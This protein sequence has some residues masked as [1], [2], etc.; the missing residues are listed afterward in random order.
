M[1]LKNLITADR[2]EAMLQTKR[3]GRP[4]FAFWRI[5]STNTFARDQAMQGAPEGTLVIA[6][7]QTRGRGRMNRSW[8]SACCRGLWFSIILRPVDNSHRA[9]LYPYLVGVSVA[10]TI[11][12]V[13]GLRPALKWPND[14]LINGHKCCG[15]LAEADFSNGRIQY[16]ILGIGL[17]VLHHHD[18][19]SHSLKHEATSL[20]LET[21]LH[22]DRVQLLANILRKMEHQYMVVQTEGFEPILKEWKQRCPWLHKKITVNQGDQWLEGFFQDLDSDGCLLLRVPKKGIHKIVAGDLQN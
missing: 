7:E 11:E 8:E 21:H 2:I 15:I 1:N 20:F 13:T 16:I 12:E 22:F 9:G 14:I 4:I 19:F 17:N 18:D 5:G 3:L 10:H 6:E